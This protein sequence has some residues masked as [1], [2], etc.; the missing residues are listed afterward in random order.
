L[1]ARRRAVFRLPL[2]ECAAIDRRPLSGRLPRRA[3]HPD[4][5]GIPVRI[6]RIT[7][8][9]LLSAMALAACDNGAKQ[10]LATISHTDSLRVDSLGN[11]RKDLLEEVMTST[12][13]VNQINTELAKARALAAEQKNVQ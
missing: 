13:F 1:R 7:P 9:A 11:V 4:C 2:P 6:S 8:I 10:Q 5:E 12:Q 3:V